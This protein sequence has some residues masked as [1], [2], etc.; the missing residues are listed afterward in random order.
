M[1]QAWFGLPR[2][3]FRLGMRSIS[4]MFLLRAIGDFRTVG[5]WKSITDTPF[6]HWDTRLYSPLC[7]GIAALAAITDVAADAALTADKPSK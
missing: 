6:A 5:F 1:Q 2:G 4:L 7:L 3:L